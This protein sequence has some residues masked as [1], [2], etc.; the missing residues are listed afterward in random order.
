[1]KSGD[2]NLLGGKIDGICQDKTIIEVK[3]R[4]INYSII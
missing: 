2:Y 4:I 1:M 3:D